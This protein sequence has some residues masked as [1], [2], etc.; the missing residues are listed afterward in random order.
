[1]GTPT[2][3]F[4]AAV[5]SQW[6]LHCHG[7]LRQAS[8]KLQQILQT[9]NLGKLKQVT[10]CWTSCSRALQNAATAGLRFHMH[11]L[12][13]PPSR[14]FIFR[15][16]LGDCI[17]YM[18]WYSCHPEIVQAL[19]WLFHGP[20]IQL[21]RFRVA[22]SRCGSVWQCVVSRERAYALQL[23][24]RS[25]FYPQKILTVQVSVNTCMYSHICY[26]YTH[27]HTHTDA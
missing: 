1:M 23:H 25:W 17:N 6:L 9:I 4:V 3:A 19:G 11:S 21:R 22:M 5:P 18:V 24:N 16:F 20:A 13:I 8:T 15:V 7:V 12:A 26:T 10:S 14:K 2:A 27:P